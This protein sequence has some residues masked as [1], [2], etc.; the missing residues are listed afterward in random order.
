MRVGLKARPVLLYEFQVA[1]ERN[2]LVS[3]SVKHLS[4]LALPGGAG[5]LEML[6]PHVTVDDSVP[7]QEPIQKSSAEQS[8]QFR[9]GQQFLLCF[10]VRP[11]QFH[12]RDSLTLRINMLADSI[13]ALKVADFTGGKSFR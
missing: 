10:L 2:L 8:P 6:A 13:D 9:I 4:H 11:S 3:L 12:I 5:W 1:V 7:I